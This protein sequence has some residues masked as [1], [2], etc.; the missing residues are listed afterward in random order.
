MAEREPEFLE[1]AGRRGVVP[2]WVHGNPRRFCVWW[3]RLLAHVCG[4]HP[5]SVCAS[6]SAARG[7]LKALLLRQMRCAG[8]SPAPFTQ[9]EG[10]NAMIHLPSNHYVIKGKISSCEQCSDSL[11]NSNR[12]PS[13][14]KWITQHEL[15]LFLL[16][17]EGLFWKRHPVQK[18]TKL[19]NL[20]S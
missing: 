7:G 10:K 6:P 19:H 20:R 13:A 8:N 3:T 16:F 18:P 15:T 17:P 1:A 11:L 12:S 14:K 2:V 5:A 9:S 4:G